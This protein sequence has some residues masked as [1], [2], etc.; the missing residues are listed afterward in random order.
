MKRLELDAGNSFIKW[1][2][3]E[4]GR[5]RRRGSWL[6][7]E[8][9]AERLLECGERP[10]RIWFASVAGEVFDRALQA[11]V[12]RYWQ[13][14]LQRACAQAEAAGVRNSYKDPA[15][16]GV[17]RWLALLAAWHQVKDACWVVDCGSAITVD[18]LDAAGC[19][20]GGYILPGLRLMRQALLGNT[21]GVTVDRPVDS[22]VVMPGRDTS[23]G[24]EHGIN[25]LL[26]SL[27][28]QL[29]NDIPG[30]ADVP[31]RVLVTGGDGR[32]WLEVMPE[33]EWCPD[34]VMDGLR[35]ALE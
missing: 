6:T 26:L 9:S 21:A 33:A 17:D 2:L 13:V 14:P 4:Q 1:R 25:L 29:K 18:L 28:R 20:Q 7:A 35:W 19:H 10:D 23:S 34:L 30:V 3:L 12:E 8:F 16:M 32:Q 11:G 27:A 22:G 31:S 24:V 15:R 5:V